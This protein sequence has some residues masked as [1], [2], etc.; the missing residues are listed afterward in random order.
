MK[1]AVTNPMVKLH[2]HLD[3]E[4][5]H[6]ASVESL[7]AKRISSD[8]GASVFE[9][10]NSPFYA[11]GVSFLDVVRAEEEDGRLFFVSV[12]SSAGHSTYRLRV[13]WPSSKFEAAWA[14]LTSFGCTYE[15]HSHGKT[16]LFAV[17]VPPDADIHAVYRL[18]EE[19]EAE[20]IWEFEEGHCGHPT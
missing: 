8:T 19:G 5:W 10:D 3:P 11:F 12:A 4:S 7:W 15:G 6:G 9:L 17:D 20:G 14:R 18:F 2:F 1:G 16:H 13:P